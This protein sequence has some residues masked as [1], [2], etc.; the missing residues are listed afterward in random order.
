MISK[1]THSLGARM[2]LALVAVF[3]VF[4]VASAVL[5]VKNSHQY[6]FEV[7]QEMH[8]ELAQHVVDEYLLFKDGKPDR[9]A[10][11]ASFHDLMILGPNF[12]FYLLDKTGKI[13]SYSAEQGTV[14]LDRVDLEPINAFIGQ[15]NQRVIV[16]DDPKQPN[17]KKIF[18]AAPIFN[19]GEV[20]GYL[21]AVIGSQARE[22]VEADVFGP[23]LVQSSLAVFVFLVVLTVLVSYLIILLIARPLKILTNQVR[24]LG[25]EGFDKFQGEGDSI[26]QALGQWDASSGNDI[27]IVGANFRA[28]LIKLEQQYQ[29]IVSIDELRKELLSHVSHD[30]RTPLASL[31]GYLETWEIQQG[32][33][34]EQQS[35]DYIATARK[36]AKKIVVLIEQ[37]FDLA[38]LDSNNVTVKKERVVVAEL[39]QDV[40]NKFALS[41]KEKHITL[42]LQPLDI[43][44]EVHADMEKLERVFTNLIENAMRH[45]PEH[46]VITINLIKGS[47]LVSIEVS[48]TG[49]GIPEEDLPHIFDPHFKAGNSV[50]ENTAHGGLGL[51]IT[52]KLLELHQT[53]I[54]VKSALHKGTTFRFSL[55]SA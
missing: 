5:F 23:K 21:Y 24:D 53:D 50:R 55:A 1:F 42:K 35:R 27:D 47:S 39:V 43:G 30:L 41:A 31:L 52:K 28:A 48:D 51:A 45:T 37:L 22:R 14:V 4:G 12:E 8:R 44:I 3:V 40:L 46:G 34:T 26:E 7:S 17:K 38:N 13:V 54:T 19:M 33:M 11:K 25:R 9:V 49:I 32:Q 20:Y 16:G 36:N 10:A 18:S 6:E 15:V 2:T 29:H